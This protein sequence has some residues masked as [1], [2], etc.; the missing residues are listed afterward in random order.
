MKSFCRIC[1]SET[2][3][4]EKRFDPTLGFICAECHGFLI[5]ADKVLCKCGIEGVTIEPVRY[6]HDPKKS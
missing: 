2:N 3:D 5:E 4:L 1:R 6:K